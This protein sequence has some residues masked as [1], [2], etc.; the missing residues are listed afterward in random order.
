M[1][2]WNNPPYYITAYGLAVKHGYTGTEEQWLESLKGDPGEG[3]LVERSF[4]SYAEMVSYYVSSKP[5]GFVEVGSTED[6][7]LYYWDTPN[8]EWRS[9]S[10]IGPQGPQGIQGETGP[11]G[12]PGPPIQILG[13]EETVEELPED[14]EQGD[15]YNVGEEEPY[16]IYMWDNGAWLNLGKLQGPQGIQGET[17]PQGEPGPR[18]TSGADGV[19]YTPSVSADGVLSWTNDGDRENPESVNIKGPQGREGPQG[20]QGETGPRGPMG[21]QGE[22][23]EPGTSIKPLG[24]KESTEELPEFANQGDMYF[25][26]T[27]APY[28]IYMWDNGEWRDIG[29]LSGP[30]G[31]DGADGVSPTVSITSITGGHRVSVTD[32]EGTSTFD[33]MDGADGAQ[34]PAGN[35]GND[36]ADGVS[37]TVSITSITGGHRVSVTDAGGTDSFD[38]MDGDDYVLTAQDKEDIAEGAA[39]DLSPILA[40]AEESTT[41]SQA[42]AEGEYFLLG[43]SLY[44]A[45][46]AITQG[47]TITPGSNCEAVTVGEELKDLRDEIDAIPSSTAL[48]LTL[49]AGSWSSATPPTQT[50]TATGVRATSNIIV[51]IGSSATGTQ[52]EQAAAAM[53]VCTAQGTDEITLTCY[54]EEP[55]GNIPI[56]VMILP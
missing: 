51:G 8:Q 53:I 14:A 6:Y 46:A 32:A 45:T 31:N 33:V 10:I 13:T 37:P 9:I 39:E 42:Y 22:Q 40:E 34:G 17:G 23:G 29:Q 54:G 2:L 48:S 24:T 4:D 5:K 43:G 41:A 11:Q 52:Y 35:D 16:D 47:G 50:L 3:L 44:R 12:V 55:S 26:G 38:V 49:A 18:G 30:P 15:M 19:T 27:E 21:P 7:L 1:S 25:V 28:D 36:G 20:E 56:S